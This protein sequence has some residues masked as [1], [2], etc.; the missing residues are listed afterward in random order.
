MTSPEPLPPFDAG[1]TLLGESPAQITTALLDTP[2]GQRLVLTVRTPSTTVT[3]L[4]NKE[5]G[6]SW[7]RSVLATVNQM[8]GAGLFVAPGVLR[9]NGKVAA[10]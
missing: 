10:S 8:S 4:L 3:V 1:N 6:Q 9:N 7:G 5:D 2:A